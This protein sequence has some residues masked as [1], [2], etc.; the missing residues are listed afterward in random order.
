M[1]ER[2]QKVAGY[3]VATGKGK[4]PFMEDANFICELEQ[5]VLVGL[6]DAHW[7]DESSKYAAETI[8][9]KIKGYIKSLTLE[10]SL[11]LSFLNT[12]LELESMGI[13]G[14]TTALVF[15]L[16]SETI[17]WANSGDSRVTVIGDRIN[18]LNLEHR[19]DNPSERKRIE[20]S[21]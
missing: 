2:R 6:F 7:G 4:N 9:E 1:I 3:F 5:G 17:T 11:E 15:L 12:S 21:C 20:E 14:G 8:P 18:Q 13:I 10:Q 16:C 19:A